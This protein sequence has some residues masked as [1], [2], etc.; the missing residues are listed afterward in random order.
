MDDQLNQQL[1]V[2]LRELY[3]IIHEKVS[4]KSRNTPR[5]SY[6]QQRILH[7]SVGVASRCQTNKHA[8]INELKRTNYRDRQLL[9]K[10]S[11][12]CTHTC[13]KTPKTYL[14]DL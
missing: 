7:Y 13:K 1:C 3:W 2:M 5:N 14:E 12:P 11:M 10:P 6:V 4:N 9:R 8:Q